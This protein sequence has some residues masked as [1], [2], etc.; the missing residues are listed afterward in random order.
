MQNRKRKNRQAIMKSA[1]QYKKK[2]NFEGCWCFFFILLVLKIFLSKSA[3]SAVSK[4]LEVSAKV[5]SSKELTLGFELHPLCAPKF[6]HHG[7]RSKKV[8]TLFG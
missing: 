1:K 4:H 3:L 8:G 6:T 7:E 2:E 5:I